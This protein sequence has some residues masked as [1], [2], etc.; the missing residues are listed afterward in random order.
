MS[1]STQPTNAMFEDN[2]IVSVDS[3]NDS[4]Y[5]LSPTGV[6]AVKIA[7]RV[8]QRLVDESQS[9][10]TMR[11]DSSGLF[12]SLNASPVKKVDDN[13]FNSIDC[14]FSMNN[15]GE[16]SKEM[17]WV[18]FEPTEFQPVSTEK[19]NLLGA[20]PNKSQ[21]ETHSAFTPV[22]FAGVK[23]T[24]VT[25]KIL[26]AEETTLVQQ[27]EVL[28][29]RLALLEEQVR[30]GAGTQVVDHPT[31]ISDSSS[32]AHPQ[33]VAFIEDTELLMYSS[34]NDETVCNGSVKEEKVTAKQR[35][36]KGFAR[37]V[38]T[39]FFRLVKSEKS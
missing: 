9:G 14:S 31:Q 38:L 39:S 37:R 16:E 15:E 13:T 18:E 19:S 33:D 30:A 36:G 34:L 22:I 26:S 3:T 23:P 5:Q 28:K 7:S 4:F 11:D 27:M 24:L 25:T 32:D 6:E 12:P 8:E 29:R 21:D 20:R 2:S 35:K 10:L 17:R 1:V